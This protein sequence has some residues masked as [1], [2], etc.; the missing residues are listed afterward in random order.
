MVPGASTRVL[1]V[2][3]NIANFTLVQRL[4]EAS[5]RFPV[6]RAPS[7]EDARETLANGPVPALILLD[8]ELPGM[9]GIEFAREIKSQA[10]LAKVPLVLITASVMKQERAQAMDA[11]VDRFIEKPFDIVML[12]NLVEELT[13][14]TA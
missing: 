14:S 4:L 2:E 11:G 5:D 8:H 10:K 3:D 13:G 1:Y 7:A 12:R 9:L 6:E